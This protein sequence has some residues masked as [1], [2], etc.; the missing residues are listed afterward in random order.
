M[1]APMFTR[2][3]GLPIP[4]ALAALSCLVVVACGGD[5]PAEPGSAA[6]PSGP[7]A[8]SARLSANDVA[9]RRRIDAWRGGGPASG[10]PPYEVVR[11]ARYVQ[12]TSRLFA[13]EPRLAAAT[14]RR[15]PA[16][17]ARELGAFSVAGR[18]LRR[19]SAGWPARKVRIG[20]PRPLP[21]L[22]GYYRTAQRRFGVGWNVLAAV[23]LVESAFG[24]VRSAS[25][26]GAQ[27]PM[28]FIPATWRTYGLGGN[29]RDPHDAILGAANLLSQSGAPGSYQRALY[30]YNPS[31]L[32]VDAVQR[33]ARV[34]AHDPD[35]I[36]L[37]YCW[38]G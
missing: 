3:F 29:V 35:A 5:Q 19:L 14:L 21:E 34:M 31:R 11:R 36:Y 25:V 4:G 1:M 7:G 37:L 9:L 6:L 24:R 38:R 28:Q 2:R 27:G 22:L 15:L 16:R 18:D 13:R 30:A 33:Y 23:H 20:L 12:R 8:L 10:P 26:A 32:Y 17:L